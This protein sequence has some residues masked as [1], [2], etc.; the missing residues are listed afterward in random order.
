MLCGQPSSESDGRRRLP[1]RWPGPA[2][3]VA[4]ALPSPNLAA[5]CG[6]ASEHGPRFYGLPLNE[7]SVTLVREPSEVPGEIAGVVPWHADEMLGW[8]LA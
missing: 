2:G 4:I 5:A 1:H 3:L 8:K 6:F 7:G